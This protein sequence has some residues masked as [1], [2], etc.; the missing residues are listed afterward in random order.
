MSDNYLTL[1]SKTVDKIEEITLTDYEITECKIE[2]E[3][4][5]DVIEDLILQYE[6]LLEEYNN[7]KTYI[8]DN[9]SFKEMR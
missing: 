2:A 4:C 8:E 9:Y 6:E 7:Y 1:D 3:K 5:L